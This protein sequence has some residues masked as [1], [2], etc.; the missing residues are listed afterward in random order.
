MG[1][2]RV[3]ER[4]GVA[5]RVDTTS[6]NMFRESW[7]QGYDAHFFANVFHDWSLETCASLAA[8]SFAALERGGRIYLQEI[9]LDDSGDNPTIAVA[10]SLLMCLGTKGQQFTFGQLKDILESAG[11]TGV[12]TQRSYGYYSI[13]T[14][15][16]A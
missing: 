4:A 15:I 11:F 16:K 7:P 14:G 2:Q 9:L 12:T 10:F 8:S 6:V 5:D 13:V 3:F 1:G